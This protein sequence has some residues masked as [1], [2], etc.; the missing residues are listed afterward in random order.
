MGLWGIH[1]HFESELGNMKGYRMSTLFQV[2]MGMEE[3]AG[4]NSVT[5]ITF[6]GTADTEIM[7]AA[8]TVKSALYLAVD[9]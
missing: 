8:L 2:E 5:C 4:W 3:R 1:Q 6:L 9:M 7:P